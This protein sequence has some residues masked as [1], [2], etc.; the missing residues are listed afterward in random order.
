VS[1]KES[2]KQNARNPRNQATREENILWYEFLK[3]QTP[4][5]NRQK[6][7]GPY[8]ADFYCRKVGLVVELDGSQHY[9]PEH[10]QYD[11]K[12]TAY[13]H[14]L[15]IEVLRFT[16]T[17]IK[18]NLQGVCYVIEKTVEE[19]LAKEEAFRRYETA[20]GNPQSALRR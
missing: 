20:S 17:E 14:D 3:K 18:K 11:A 1:D 8:I 7:I 4:P 10:I 15:N 2:L 12:R 13:F 6:V 16:N 5:W 9:D 19:L